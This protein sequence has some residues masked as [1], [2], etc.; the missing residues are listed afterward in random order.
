MAKTIKIICNWTDNTKEYFK[1]QLKNGTYWDEFILTNEK[2]ADFYVIINHIRPTQKDAYYEENKTIFLTMEPSFS[3]ARKYFNDYVN[4][5]T[6]IYY[7][8]VNGLEWWIHKSYDQLM[9]MNITKTKNISS[10]VSNN[11]FSYYHKKR[12]DFLKYIDNLD[13]IDLFGRVDKPV[14]ESYNIITSLK[15]YKGQLQSKDY[16]LFPYKYT[17]VCENAKENN[18]FTEKLSD[19][20][21]C[22]CLCFYCGCPNIQD[23]INEKAYIVIDVENP[24]QA[25]N[26][27]IEAIQTNQWEKRIKYIREAKMKILNELQLIPTITNVIKN[28]FSSKDY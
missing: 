3:N 11:Y 26:I 4:A 16:G 28:N 7:H 15:N 17:F 25:M 1:K 21:L 19:G 23:F 22:E 13:E 20:I 9:S 10:I 5:N 2:K 14:Q 27:I 8:N 24:E 12:V 6:K 18:Y